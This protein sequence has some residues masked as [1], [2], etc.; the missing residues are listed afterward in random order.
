MAPLFTGLKLGGFGKN[1]DVVSAGLPPV[2]V[3]IYLWGGYGGDGR[4]GTPESGGWVRVSGTA[5][6]GTTIGYITGQSNG[7]R[8]FYTGGSGAGNP[9]HG[10]RT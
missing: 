10:S 3:N 9:S 5:T 6:P 8:N 1:P 7:S 2:P 4:S